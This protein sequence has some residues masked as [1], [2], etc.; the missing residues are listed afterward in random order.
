MILTFDHVSFQYPGTNVPVLENL[1]FAMDRKEFVSLIGPSG[2]GKT[3]ILRLINGFN[4]PD[5]GKIRIQDE[6]K[7]RI[8][9]GGPT[10][11]S[12]KKSIQCGYMPQND[13]LF[14]WN[15]VLDNVALPLRIQKVSKPERREK[16]RELLARVGLEG[17]ENKYPKELSG[18]MR[19]RASFA[20]TLATGA[21]L[22]LLDE[23]F[24]ALDSITR[25]SMQE[26]MH[27][28]WR[29]MNKTI[30][31]ITHDVEEAI[32][33]SGRILVMTGIPVRQMKEIVVP[34]PEN[35]NREM[36]L[37]GEIMKMKQELIEMLRED[38]E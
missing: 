13:L 15:T 3:T 2:S 20:R 5:A 36:L 34:L 23:P 37:S 33:L 12:G 18:G 31:M 16:A 19:Q 35:R 22:L 8:R 9:E 32:F 28:Q 21:D 4:Q 25:A 24:S 10:S 7:R 27:E 30:L 6:E 17:Y 26:W 14:P 1:S 38:M 29:T 11:E